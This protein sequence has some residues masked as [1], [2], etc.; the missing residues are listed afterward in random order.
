MQAKNPGGCVAPYPTTRAGP[1]S[2][3][4]AAAG[5]HFPKSFGLADRALG[6][7]HQYRLGTAGVRLCATGQL[8]L[9]RLDGSPAAAQ[10]QSPAQ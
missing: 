1:A 6:E 7:V 8:V 5:Q 10:E 9:L 2:L 4:G 3:P